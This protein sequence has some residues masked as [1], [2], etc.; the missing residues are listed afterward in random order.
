MKTFLFL[1]L[2]F[3]GHSERSAAFRDRRCRQN[4]NSNF[5]LHQFDSAGPAGGGTWD[6]PHQKSCQRAAGGCAKGSVCPAGF[7]SQFMSL[8]GAAG[9][10]PTLG[11]SPQSSLWR[12]G[13]L[14]EHFLLLVDVCSTVGMSF[15]NSLCGF[16]K[17]K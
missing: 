13:E 15:V 14:E 9:T 6:S 1:I 16:L 8:P 4:H 2:I 11:I 10:S 17:S 7:S 3:P 5:L 12:C